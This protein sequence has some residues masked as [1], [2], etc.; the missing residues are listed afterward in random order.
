MS[1]TKKL[2]I[3]IVYITFFQKILLSHRVKIFGG[4][5][6][7]NLSNFEQKNRV[8]TGQFSLS[9]PYGEKKKEKKSE[10]PKDKRVKKG[11]ASFAAFPG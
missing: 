4:F 6:P 8:E 7:Q 5:K 10:K 11:R 3:S 2:N 1:T 9:L